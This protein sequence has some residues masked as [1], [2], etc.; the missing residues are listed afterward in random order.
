MK[1]SILDRYTSE[2]PAETGGHPAAM[3]ESGASASFDR[4]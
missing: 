3:R 4:D 2:I 1:L